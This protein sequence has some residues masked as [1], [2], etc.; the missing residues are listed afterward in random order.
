MSGEHIIKFGTYTMQHFSVSGISGGSRISETVVPRRAGVVISEP[1]LSKRMITVQGVVWGDDLRSKRD[2]LLAALNSGRQKL[3]LWDDRYI[4]AT[5]NSF[6]EDY[7]AGAFQM[8][9]NAA[10]EF[11]CDDPYFYSEDETVFDWDDVV[12]ATD[13]DV[14]VVAGQAT[15]KP[16]I[17]LTADSTETADWT[18]DIEGQEF[19]IQGEVTSGLVIKIDCENQ[20]VTNNSTGADLFA[21]FDGEFPEL[22]VGNNYIEYT[23]E[24]GTAAISRIEAEWVDKWL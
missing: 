20:T 14:I 12:A 15:V 6:T 22:A 18:I 13:T 16:V 19:A 1:A 10:A 17:R 2:A 4:W 5:K 11:V 3:Y 24:S 8:Y 23:R 9:F 7:Q 21:L